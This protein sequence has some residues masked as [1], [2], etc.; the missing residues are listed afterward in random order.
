MDPR[1][2]SADVNASATTYF[3][4]LWPWSLTARI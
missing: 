2:A 1:R 4:M 3:G